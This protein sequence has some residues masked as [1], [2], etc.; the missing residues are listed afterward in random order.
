[1]GDKQKMKKRAFILCAR[2]VSAGEMEAEGFR[3]GVDMLIAADAGL[4]NA[5]KL[6]LAPQAAIGDFDSCVQ[7]SD[8][9]GEL[10][11]YPKRK[12]STDAM[13]AV[14]YCLKAGIKDIVLMGA[15]GGRLDHTFANLQLL[16]F[17]ESIGARGLISGE[18]VRC[19]IISGV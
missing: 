8:F 4:E 16:A 14:Q 1:M 15:L 6:G 7:P 3:N 5:R 11:V 17:L 19:R 10:L 9:G 2:P 12:D 18:G 13:L